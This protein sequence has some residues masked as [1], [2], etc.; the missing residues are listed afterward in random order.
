MASFIRGKEMEK[1]LG[2]E[3]AAP[4]SERAERDTGEIVSGPRMMAKP[5][6]PKTDADKEMS[7][8]RREVIESRNLVIKTDHL[9]KTLHAEVKAVGKR[10]EDFQKRQWISSAAA[11]VIFAVLAIT[12]SIVVGA[13]RGS[14]AKSEKER[15]QKTIGELTAKLEK[16]LADLHLSQAASRSAADAYRQMTTASGDDRLK[17]AEGLAK[18]DTSRISPLEKQA[19]SDRAEALREEIGQAA[20]ERGKSAFRKNDMKTAIPELSRFLAMKPPE[21]EALDAS[22]YLGVA[23]VLS[24]RHEEAVPVLA[25]FVAQDKKAKSRDYAMLLLTHSYEQSG[26]LDKAAQT[27]REAIGT[28]PHSDFATQLRTRLHS[29]QKAM[30]SGGA[31]TGKPAG[32]GAGDEAEATAAAGT[33]R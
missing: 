14:I 18:L 6:E 28:Y 32:Q 13:V 12:A 22:Y 17:G 8:I 20:L 26:Q 10:Y 3:R 5:T 24:K 7:E 1:Q 31:G 30:S 27:A 23:Y 19:L 9:L 11:Y 33:G 2:G 29:I 25:R 4:S 21:K 16:D 15:L